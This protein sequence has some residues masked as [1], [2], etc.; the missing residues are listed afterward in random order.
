[1]S[2]TNCTKEH[3]AETDKEQTQE[4]SELTATIEDVTTKTHLDGA[5]VTWEK[6]DQIAIQRSIEHIYNT[7]TLPGQKDQYK[8]TFVISVRFIRQRRSSILHCQVMF[9][10]F[11]TE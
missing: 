4:N 5:K 8:T 1:M 2:L 6:G 9:W 3:V 7:T 11:T 10:H